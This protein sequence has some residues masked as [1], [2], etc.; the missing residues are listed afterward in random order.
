MF[1]ARLGCRVPAFCRERR[2]ILKAKRHQRLV[3]WTVGED[4]ISSSS[5]QQQPLCCERLARR[6]PQKVA[7]A[8][9]RQ[10]GATTSS[11]EVVQDS[12]RRIL[13]ITP[14]VILKTLRSPRNLTRLPRAVSARP[15]HSLT[16]AH[17]RTRPRSSRSEHNSSQN[18]YLASPCSHPFYT[19]KPTLSGR[20]SLFVQDFHEKALE[21]C[22]DVH[23]GVDVVELGA[24]ATDLRE[25]L[26]SGVPSKV[27]FC[28]NDLQA[29]T[30][31]P[32][33]SCPRPSRLWDASSSVCS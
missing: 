5:R 13:F 17:V 18:R 7:V 19:R 28:H 14:H 4:A 21:L 23:G 15:P 12:S 26:E 6:S 1:F 33:S 31:A 32:C 29:S 3:G 16:R 27:V 20:S 8:T 30:W 11:R 25:R 9:C 22:G 10:G 24:L 2:L